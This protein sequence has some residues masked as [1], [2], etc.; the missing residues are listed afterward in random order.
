MAQLPSTPPWSPRFGLLFA[1]QSCFIL[2]HRSESLPGEAPRHRQA[3][4]KPQDSHWDSTSEPSAVSSSHQ[5]NAQTL[6]LS[7]QPQGCSP[8]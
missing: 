3:P 5:S 6:E 8:F 4:H 2:M 1:F 7:P